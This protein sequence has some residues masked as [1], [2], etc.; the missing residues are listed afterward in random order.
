M[1]IISAGLSYYS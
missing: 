1:T